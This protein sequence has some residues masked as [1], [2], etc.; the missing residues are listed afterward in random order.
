MKPRGF[1]DLAQE[2][3]QRDSEPCQRTAISRAY[4]A[5]FH[6]AR[7]LLAEWGFFIRQSDRAHTAITRRLSQSGS[8][9]L[10][11]IS[12]S[13]IEF[14]QIRNKADYDLDRTLDAEIVKREMERVITLF[15][16]IAQDIPNAERDLAIQKIRDYERDVLLE[17]TWFSK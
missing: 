7:Q 4:Y 13:L 14:K 10:N 17:V 8:V 15:H 5:A 9:T 2:L 11:L 3:A 6:Q 16:L 12:Q 1:L